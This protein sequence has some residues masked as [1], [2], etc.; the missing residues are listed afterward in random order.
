[1]SRFLPQRLRSMVGLMSC[2]GVPLRRAGGGPARIREKQGC[3]SR[4]L[5]RLGQT[6]LKTERVTARSLLYWP[7]RMPPGRSGEGVGLPVC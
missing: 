4:I 3:F 2:A 6:R 1:M 7:G 5:L